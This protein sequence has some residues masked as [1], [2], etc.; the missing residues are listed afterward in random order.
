MLHHYCILHLYEHTSRKYKSTL[1]K[2]GI[3]S[4]NHL[5]LHII[6]VKL[7]QDQHLDT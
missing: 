3:L 5:L 6:S 4:F 1:N 7:E 2:E